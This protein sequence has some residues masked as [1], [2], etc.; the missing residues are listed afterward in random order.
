MSVERNIK[1]KKMVAL[2]LVLALGT[3]AL[4]CT[5][6]AETTVGFYDDFEKADLNGYTVSRDAGVTV[7]GDEGS[8]Y[9]NIS[10]KKEG[11][12]S[13]AELEL[14]AQENAPL[15]ISYKFRINSYIDSGQT[16]A[17]ISKNGQPGIVIETYDGGLAYKSKDGEYIKF[18]ENV[19]AN[20]WYSICITA[21]Y[22]KSTFSIRLDGE[23]LV[24]GIANISNSKGADKISFRAKYTP[25]IAIDD[26]SVN[27]V[28][29]AGKV[30]ING[31][32]EIKLAYDTQAQL[33]YVVAIYDT[34]DALID[35]PSFSAS[36]IP[37]GS[38]VT[39]A[40]DS[41]RI[42]L[43][44]AETAA[45]GDYTL[46][47][48]YKNA[49]KNFHFR[50]E[51][52]TSQ[53]ESI[54]LS[55]AGRIAYIKGKEN[56]FPYSVT[57]FDQNGMAIDNAQVRWFIE[58]E[59]PPFVTIDSQTG[60]L[61]VSGPLENN[62][63]IK[64]MAECT[65]NEQIFASKRIL[66]QDET[67]YIGDEARFRVLLDYVDRAREVGRDPYNG[68]ILLAKAIDRYTMKPAI[69]KGLE[70]DFVPSNLAE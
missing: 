24:R 26:I 30:E 70:Y 21:D 22:T 52:Y 49:I 35:A 9:M 51:R 42:I 53:V 6:A 64:I 12:A 31:E 47:V 4:P 33:D 10:P 63:S 46:R 55:G 7:C 18:L 59:C 43:S 38:G 17:H 36:I 15:V 14:D 54:T 37:T 20:K 69:W 57:A 41:R 40:I 62:V 61:T 13:F 68:S 32:S 66:C 27:A 39:A 67:T 1:R 23:D 19:V 25:G 16:I 5:A 44:V 2:A 50:L 29:N 28:Q 11:I 34:N 65:G 56:T 45:D 3:A 48:V 60:V 58:G 8:R